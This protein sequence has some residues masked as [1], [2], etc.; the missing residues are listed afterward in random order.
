M[1]EIFLHESYISPKRL[2]TDDVNDLM[3]A[4]LALRN[5]S[6]PR[7]ND[8][9]A[10]RCRCLLVRFLEFLRPPVHSVKSAKRTD[11]PINS[12]NI[13]ANMVLAAVFAIFDRRVLFPLVFFW[14]FFWFLFPTADEEVAPVTRTTV[15]L[16]VAASNIV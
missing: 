10:A 12:K 3:L 15:E 16:T 11:A 9:S 5:N 8:F 1:F 6:P 13:I 4:M 14:F 2:N 7:S